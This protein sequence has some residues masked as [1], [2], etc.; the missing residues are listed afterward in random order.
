MKASL[1]ETVVEAAR[2]SGLPISHLEVQRYDEQNFGDTI[3]LAR[4]WGLRLRFVRDRG[5]DVLEFGP[6]DSNEERHFY[7]GDVEVACG[8]TTAENVLDRR[9]IEPLATVLHRFATGQEHLS[10]LL[11]GAAARS[12]WGRVAAAEKARGD[13]FARRLYGLAPPERTSASAPSPPGL[14]SAPRDVIE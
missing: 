8:W 6:A 12:G 9:E 4:L 13:A 5:Q 11:S 3:V 10:S 14:P 1:L 7:S 2:A